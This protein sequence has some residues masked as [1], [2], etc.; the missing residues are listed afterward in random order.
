MPKWG[1]WDDTGF[2]SRLKELREAAEMSQA[3]LAERAGCNK[4]TITKLEA[5]RQQPA[6]P[7]VLALCRALN[8]SCEVF[9]QAHPPADAKAGQQEQGRTEGKPAGRSRK[10]PP[11]AKDKGRKGG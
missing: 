7:L 8:V 2:G 1:G 9:A 6:W 10:A 5:G 4:F 3:D 11:A